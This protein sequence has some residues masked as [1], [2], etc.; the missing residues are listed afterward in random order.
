MISRKTIILFL[1]ALSSVGAFEYLR[2]NYHR[3]RVESDRSHT[4]EQAKPQPPSKPEATVTLYFDLYDLE[5]ESNRLAQSLALTSF[6]AIVGAI[7]SVIQDLLKRLKRKRPQTPS[8][9]KA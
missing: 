7:F 6:I 8:T 4:F 9:S 2:W 5:F 1:I 3:T